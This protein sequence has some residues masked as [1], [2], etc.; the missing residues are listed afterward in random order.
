MKRQG[1]HPKEALSAVKVKNLTKP[2]RYPDGNGLYLFI[3]SS[4][5]K[6][7]VLRTVIKGARRD[8][9]LGSVR[10]VPLI[11]ARAEA[12]RLRRIA[13][14]GGDPLAEKR[15]EKAESI[16]FDK[17]SADV[18]SERKDAWK[19]DKHR[20]QWLSTLTTYASPVFGSKRIG[21]VT[22]HDVLKAVQPIWLTK[23]ETAKRV[24]QRIGVV[25]DWA[26]A[27]GFFHGDNPVEG[28]R[29]GLVKQPDT[30]RHFAAMPYAEVPQFYRNIPALKT[31]RR[32]QLAL[33]LVILTA[34]RTSEVLL[35]RPSEFDLDNGLWTIPAERMKKGKEHRVPLCAAGVAIIRE[36]MELPHSA[37]MLFPGEKEGKPMSNMTLLQTLLSR[38]VGF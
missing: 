4:G 37:E 16:S 33:Q 35:A 1:Q 5:A 30:D 20:A 13:R 12:T 26:K 32:A 11:D 29:L 23:P 27:A 10:L 14:E 22:S 18:H 38:A 19:N 9:G 34:T 24:L 15:Q 21:L 28:A 6:R 2:G 8:L 3:D 31:S 36:A 25:M 7:W 17:A